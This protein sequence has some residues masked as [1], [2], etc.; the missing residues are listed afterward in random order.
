MNDTK[1]S[2]KPQR[3]DRKLFFR[4]FN[5]DSRFHDRVPQTVHLDRQTGEV[6]WVY[7]RDE[8]AEAEG[9]RAGLNGEHRDRVASEPGRYL[10]IPGVTHNDHHQILR[11][12]L[13]SDWTED[14]REAELAREAYD[15]S[16]GGWLTS[17][18]NDHAVKAYFEYKEAALQAMA[19]Q[20]LR[21]HQLK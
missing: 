20:F 19:A 16:I 12:F 13:E 4:A 11:D 7:Q 2:A 14:P 9:V 8:D 18:E 10:E 6:L 1:P 21:D 3:I 17:V 5:R 15:W